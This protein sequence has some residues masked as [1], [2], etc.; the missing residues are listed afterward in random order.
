[1]T[2]T[3][4]CGGHPSRPLGD[5]Y[6]ACDA[7][8]TVV[9]TDPYDLDDYT[10]TTSDTAFYGERYWRDH[11]PSGLGL[12]GLVERAR[13]DLSERAV[14]YLDRVLTYLSPGDRALELG[15][16]PGCFA[17]LLGQAGLRVTGIEMGAPTVDFVRTAFGID[18]RE[19]PVERLQL[20]TRVDAVIGFDLLEHLPRPLDTLRACRERLQDDGAL[21]LQ[22]PCYRGER[23]DW[24]MLVPA[25]HLFLYTE[26]SVR[27]LLAQA[28]F[29]VLEIGASLFPHDMWIVASRGAKLAAREDPL[30]ELNPQTAALI[31]LYRRAA[32]QT[33][34]RVAVEN[35]RRIH[36]VQ[37][38]DARDELAAVRVDQAEKAQLIEVLSRDLGEIREDQ[39]AKEATIC[40]LTHQLTAIRTD[41]VNKAN[42]IASTSH[43]LEAV[44]QDQRAKTALIDAMS[45]E[46]ADLRA[47]Q[48]AKEALIG[49]I[50]RELEAVRADQRAKE[51][52][53]TR[54]TEG[55]SDHGIPA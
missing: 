32:A 23:A 31:T 48:A 54:L 21:I 43:D 46:L 34:E 28:G 49:S 9:Y 16:A 17:Y 44:R 40:E 51:A 7:C 22:T 35:D 52:L 41:Q 42:L 4:W 39:R 20:E 47:D 30:A 14:Y 33:R 29:T 8:G 6:G 5:S 38:A 36:Q 2:R 50:S 1:M 12:P 55:S 27:T 37:A 10:S 53:I 18:V 26:Q 19:G 25:E 15:C 45:L 3:C 11:V 24:S 13:T